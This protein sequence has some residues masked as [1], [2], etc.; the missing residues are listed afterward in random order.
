MHR[1]ATNSY[2]REWAIVAVGLRLSGDEVMRILLQKFVDIGVGGSVN[3]DGCLDGDVAACE[4]HVQAVAYSAQEHGVRF[5]IQKEGLE[6]VVGLKSDT[7]DSAAAAASGSLIFEGS[8]N[9]VFDSV[10]SYLNSDS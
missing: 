3:G 7:V 1:V 9:H 8:W 4:Q 2:I 10:M 6:F 5:A